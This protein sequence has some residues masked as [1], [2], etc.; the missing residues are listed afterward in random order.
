MAKPSVEELMAVESR[1]NWSLIA[2]V[3]SVL[4]ILGWS[5]VGDGKGAQVGALCLALIQLACYIWFAVSAGG[6]ARPPSHARGGERIW[7]PPSPLLPSL[8][9]STISTLPC[10]VPLPHLHFMW[11]PPH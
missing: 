4:A 8:P 9:P 2:S 10:L 1:L 11:G 7:T 5:V 3:L 6:A